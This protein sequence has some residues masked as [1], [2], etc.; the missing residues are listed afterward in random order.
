MRLCKSAK[1][2]TLR[3]PKISVN[4]EGIGKWTTRFYNREILV[5]IDFQVWYNSKVDFFLHRCVA[6]WV[7]ILCV[8]CVR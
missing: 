3:N 2:A 8:S 1:R 5:A 7:G 6:S 4:H